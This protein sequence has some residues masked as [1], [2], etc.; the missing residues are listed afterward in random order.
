MELS[1]ER[2]GEVVSAVVAEL[3]EPLQP[4]LDRFEFDVSE[5][6]PPDEPDLGVARD[7]VHAGPG[8]VRVTVYKA[9]FE[10]AESES[11]LREWLREVLLEEVTTPPS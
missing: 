2:F 11:E 4:Y 9:P 3:P 6:P 1:L 10:A 8:F 5:S 7:D